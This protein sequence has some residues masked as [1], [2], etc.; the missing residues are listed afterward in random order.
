[1]EDLNMTE[2]KKTALGTDITLMGDEHVR[3]YR[4]TNGEVGYLWNG[5]KTLLLTTKGRKSGEDRTIPIIFTKVGNAYVII[6]SKGGAP[7][8][9]AWVLNIMSDPKVKVQIKGDTFDALARIAASPEREQVWAECI[10]DWPNYDV[11]QTRTERVIPVVMI[12]AA[13]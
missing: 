5:A 12:E 11:Y 13:A 1:M 3:Q 10:K 4:E 8:H 9:P 7:T 2:V 6:G